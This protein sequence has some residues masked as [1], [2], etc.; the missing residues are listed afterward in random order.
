MC[1]V[2]Q[3]TLFLAAGFVLAQTLDPKKY[4]VLVV[5][6]RSYFVFTPLL[7]DTAVGTLEFRNALEPVRRRSFK[8]SFLQGWADDI[9]FADKIVAVEPSVLDPN[10]GHALTGPRPHTPQSE[11]NP[12][13]FK[14]EEIFNKMI[15]EGKLV[16]GGTGDE[17]VPTY[18][19]TYDKLVIAVG[20]Y[21]QTFGTP[22]V[23]ENALFLKDVNDAR[24][25]RRRVLELFELA[26]LPMTPDE[27]RKCLLHIAVV[28]GGPT[29]MEFAASVTDLIHQD[30]SKIYPELI[31][32][33][34]IT[35]Y[36][37]AP[38]V[39]PMFE[40]ELADYAVKQYSRQ[41]IQIKTSHH[42]EELRKGFPGDDMAR[43]HQDEQIKGRIYTI[44][45]KEEGDVGIGMCV[46]ST[47]N[48]NN[49]FIQ[50]ALN[51]VRR[52][53]DG[54]AKI[55]TGE[56]KD[57]SKKQWTLQRDPR[58]G[59]MMVDDHFRVQ[60]QTTTTDSTS[61]ESSDPNNESIQA[62]ATM[63]DV[64]AIGDNCKLL[65][66]AL[67][68]TAQVANQEAKFLAKALNKCRESG[69]YDKLPGFNFKNMGV[70]T[71][72]GG[73]T[74]VLQGPNVRRDGTKKKGLNLKGW[75]AF[76]TWRGAYLSMTLSWRN[77]FLIPIQWLA[78]K[79]FGR[80]VSRF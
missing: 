36:D 9:N 32:F 33:V 78:V 8:G 2:C 19:V 67:P 69:D 37:V 59:V 66:G 14:E 52:Y 26:N 6:P 31:K 29:G 30:L 65:S 20:A 74:A 71:Y 24:K 73:A 15:E 57:P 35:L 46:W 23:K 76:L 38:K 4:N 45:T 43:E 27:I 48:M 44:R 50:K 64:F 39:L 41:N 25:I 7:N 1:L 70:M 17:R 3:L 21:S 10:V 40:A 55:M 16:M 34:K 13:T 62:K 61:K 49:P 58:S 42:V 47:G 79:L 53:P 54:S 28:G 22:G 68:A 18:P 5:S 11:I 56:V 63:Q 80:D 60:L 77:R 72:L 12:H 51:H 75:I